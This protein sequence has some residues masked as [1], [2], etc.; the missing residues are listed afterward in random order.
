[1]GTARTSPKVVRERRAQGISSNRGKV[2]RHFP[3]AHRNDRHLETVAR[4]AKV[5]E[6]SSEIEQAIERLLR[7]HPPPADLREEVEQELWVRSLG[8]ET[9]DELRESLSGVVKQVKDIERTSRHISLDAPLSESGEGALTMADMV[10]TEG[11]YHRSRARVHPKKPMA[12]CECG[13]PRGREAVQCMACVRDG[14]AEMAALRDEVLGIKR[15]LRQAKREFLRANL[16]AERE[17]ARE[18][19]F[20]WKEAYLAGR[21]AKYRGG[22]LARSHPSAAPN[23]NRTG[24]PHTLETRTAMSLA[25]TVLWAGE[26]GEQRRAALGVE[27]RVCRKCGFDG[28]L[29]NFAKNPNSYQGRDKICKPCMARTTR[30]YKQRRAAPSSEK[31]PR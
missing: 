30:E 29:E 6:P 18:A 19:L 3:K 4:D 2:R 10:D 5:W 26:Y 23:H 21:S 28:P 1:M 9:E 11:V 17:A 7:V 22:P 25:H 20:E 27:H 12:R 31:V 13:R 15:E 8:G 14:A 16:E 24:V